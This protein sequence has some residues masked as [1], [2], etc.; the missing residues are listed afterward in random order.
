MLAKVLS[1]AVLGIDAYP[2]EEKYGVIF[3]FLGDLP[4]EERP[5][6]MDMPEWDQ[7]GWRFTLIT[8][9]WDVTLECRQDGARE[10][11]LI[12]VAGGSP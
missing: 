7:D 3:V 6:I 10:W 12:L 4:E 9:P 5:P 1:S 2:V 11:P 8:Y